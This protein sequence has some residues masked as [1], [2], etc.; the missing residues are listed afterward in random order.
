MTYNVTTNM[1]PLQLNE[2]DRVRSI[3]QNVAIILGTWKGS[4]PLYRGF[5]ISP[6]CLHM[7]LS[8]ATAML[9]AD[10]REV[11]ERYEPRAEVV[12]VSFREEHD[13][14][15]PTVEVNILE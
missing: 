8:V 4:V 11:V 3:L 12:N 14:L 1:G 7:P 10:I 6:S 5:G 15:I 2:T 13:R 9:H